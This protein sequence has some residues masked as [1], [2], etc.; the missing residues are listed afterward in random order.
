ML[1][2]YLQT[3][4]ATRAGEKQRPYLSTLCD[5]VDEAEK[6]RQQ[7]LRD[8]RIRVGE[9]QN[10]DLDQTRIRELNESINKLLRER[11]HW[12]RRI[13]AL[14]GTDHAKLR[15]QS[16]VNDVGTNVFKHNGSYYFGA[17][18]DLPDVKEMMAERKRLSERGKA[19][20][21]SSEKSTEA[22]QQRLDIA[23]YG[24]VTGDVNFEELVQAELKAQ[25]EL[26]KKAVKRWEEEND[27][28]AGDDWDDSFLQ[29]VGRD[30]LECSEA[31]IKSLILEKKKGEVLGQLDEATRSNG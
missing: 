30:P 25:E 19:K 10:S 11:G 17:A 21:S 14:G 13:V 1:N 15:R 29:Y 24:Y 12:E 20:S 27:G 2:R 6:W 3:T 26:Q 9:I 28:S 8:I 4:R 16:D 5:D 7:I 18:R 31:E 22:L 23:Y